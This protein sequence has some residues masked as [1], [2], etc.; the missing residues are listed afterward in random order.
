[1]EFDTVLTVD[2]SIGKGVISFSPVIDSS[3]DRHRDGNDHDGNERFD[4]ASRGHWIMNVWQ[5]KRKSSPSCAVSDVED[6]A[7]GE[8]V[9]PDSNQSTSTK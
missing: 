4:E 9:M 6:D 5:R 1:M 7:N 2:G 8:E 3:V